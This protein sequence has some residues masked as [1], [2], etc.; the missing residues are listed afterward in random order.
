MQLGF[1]LASKGREVAIFVEGR[2]AHGDRDIRE[3]SATGQSL[4]GGSE[5]RSQDRGQW[6]MG[7]VVRVESG[8]GKTEARRNVVVGGKAA[9]VG[10]FSTDLSWIVARAVTKPKDVGYIRRGYHHLAPC[11]ATYTIS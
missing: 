11:A 9:K 2:G 5:C 3:T 4:V 8:G 10:C 7:G 1:V 6:S